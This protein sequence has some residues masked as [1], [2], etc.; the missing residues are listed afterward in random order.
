MELIL[1]VILKSQNSLVVCCVHVPESWIKNKSPKTLNPCKC[2]FQ[3]FISK[4]ADKKTALNKN[5]MFYVEVAYLIIIVLLQL[6][7]KYTFLQ[8]CT[9]NSLVTKL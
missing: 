7:F 5:H 1:D 6:T 8:E 9:V 4:I 2:I 3:F